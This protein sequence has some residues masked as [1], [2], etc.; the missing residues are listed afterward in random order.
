LNSQRKKPVGHLG[1]LKLPSIG[2]GYDQKSIDTFQDMGGDPNFLMP[3]PGRSLAPVHA[4]VSSFDHRSSGFH[5]GRHIFSRDKM[6]VN[7]LKAVHDLNASHEWR[8][9]QISVVSSG[10]SRE[11][12]KEGE[13]MSG[14]QLMKKSLPLASIASHRLS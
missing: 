3:T 2:K 13:T 12:P 9:Q 4:Q 11:I 7:N 5:T 1:G 14:D 6:E 10:E 8:T